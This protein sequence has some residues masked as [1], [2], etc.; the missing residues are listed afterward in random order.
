VTTLSNRNH[1]LAGTYHD[2]CRAQGNIKATFSAQMLPYFSKDLQLLA[3]G[4]IYPKVS[5]RL[6]P[7]VN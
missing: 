1:V 4:M 5:S 6:A 2:N 7:G 3:T